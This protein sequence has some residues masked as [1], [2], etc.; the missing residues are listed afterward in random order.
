[1][2]KKC[3]T[4]IFS[5]EYYTK[6]K[7]LLNTNHLSTFYPV[8]ISVLR[9]GQNMWAKKT[10][11]K[12]NNKKTSKTVRFHTFITWL[13]LYSLD[14]FY[15]V[16]LFFILLKACWLVSRFKF[17]LF[18]TALLYVKNQICPFHIFVFVSFANLILNNASLACR[19]KKLIHL[20]A[21]SMKNYRYFLWQKEKSWQKVTFRC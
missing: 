6:N 16:Q 19:K 2:F 14:G 9:F 10:Q 13:Y 20:W 3:L 11:R 7:N 8:I 15:A 1:M 17:T 4:V 5:V 12:A 21:S 18:K